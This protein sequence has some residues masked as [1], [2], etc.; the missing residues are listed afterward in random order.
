LYRTRIFDPAFVNGTAPFEDIPTKEFAAAV[1]PNITDVRSSRII[2]ASTSLDI[3][4]RTL[5]IYRSTTT[6]SMTW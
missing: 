3:K 2:A 5:P 4:Y 1:F 6:L